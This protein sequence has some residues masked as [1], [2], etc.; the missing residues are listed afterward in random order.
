[1]GSMNSTGLSRLRPA[2][3]SRSGLLA[4]LLVGALLL[5]YEANGPLHKISDIDLLIGDPSSSIEKG[6][7]GE[8]SGKHQG[9]HLGNSECA[10]ALLVVVLGASIGLLLARDTW[11][12]SRV[13]GSCLLQRHFPLVVPHLARGPTSSLLQVFRL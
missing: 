4:L 13:A 11:T 8:H 10:A 7:M 1:M 5:C 3:L 2:G 9:G 6:T 12:R